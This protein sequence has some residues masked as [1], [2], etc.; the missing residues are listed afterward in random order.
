MH[1]WRF[2]GLGLALLISIS[3][4]VA[5]SGCSSVYRPPRNSAVRRLGAILGCPYV[6]TTV[7]LDDASCCMN[8]RFPRKIQISTNTQARRSQPSELCVL[9]NTIEHITGL[10]DMLSL[11][12]TSH[13]DWHRDFCRRG[14]RLDCPPGDGS[15]GIP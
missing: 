9:A 8:R 4:V 12:N 10:K 14:L 13:L 3:H 5:A 6:K 11:E 15:L 1:T 7:S 2:A